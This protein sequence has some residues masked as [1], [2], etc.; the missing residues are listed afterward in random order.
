MN[1]GFVMVAYSSQQDYRQLYAVFAEMSS[2][3]A[4]VSGEL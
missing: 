3:N 2:G 4:V 1:C